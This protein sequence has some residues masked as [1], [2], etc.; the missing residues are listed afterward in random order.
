MNIECTLDTS[1]ERSFS[2]AT[3]N[4]TASLVSGQ[5]LTISLWVKLVMIKGAGNISNFI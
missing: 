2:F 3:V 5:S 1:S 4:K